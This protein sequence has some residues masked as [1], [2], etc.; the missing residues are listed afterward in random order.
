MNNSEELRIYA[1]NKFYQLEE[2][3]L[4]EL[5]FLNEEHPDCLDNLTKVIEA[6]RKGEL[7]VRWFSPKTTSRFYGKASFYGHLFK[8]RDR[9]KEIAAMVSQKMGSHA[10][11]FSFEVFQKRA[12]E[13]DFDRFTPIELW[14]YFSLDVQ[15]KQEGHE[16]DEYLSVDNPYLDVFLLFLEDLVT[17][18]KEG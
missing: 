3:F 18:R 17:K 12:K 5:T 15:R 4:R 7:L 11:H 1:E 9:C 2:I 10:N 6:G 16:S 13:G 14:E 8:D